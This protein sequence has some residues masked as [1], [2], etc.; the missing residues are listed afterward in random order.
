MP[1]EQEVDAAMLTGHQFY[2]HQDTPVVG[3][4]RLDTRDG[5]HWV[6]VT[7]KSL[8]ALAKACEKHAAQL[9]DYS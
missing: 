3:I 9:K 7:R 8:L 1:E 5:P 6:A 2:H 4:L